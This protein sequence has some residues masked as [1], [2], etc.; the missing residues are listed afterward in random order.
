MRMRI[1]AATTLTAVLTLAGAGTALANDGPGPD[2]TT[3]VASNSPGL[4]SGNVT[5]VP[6]HIPVAVCGD[7]IDVIGLLNPATGNSCTNG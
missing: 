2:T 4:L 5:Q 7:T 1:V 3:G 6:I